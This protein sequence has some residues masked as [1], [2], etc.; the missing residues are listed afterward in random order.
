MSHYIHEDL[1]FL[2]WEAKNRKDLFGKV[3]EILKNGDYIEDGFL[4]YLNNREDE[5]P[6]ALEI[7]H[8]SVAIPHGD[9][10]YIKR[11]FI[12]IIRLVDPITMYKMEDATESTQVKLFFLLGLKEGNAHLDI[13]RQVIKL[14]QDGQIITHL[15]TAKSTEKIMD[16]LKEQIK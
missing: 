6:T 12:A 14:I 3:A 1:I 9:P 10:Q 2:D 7:D 8:Y 15:E 13:L 4:D 11:P 5:Y 16:I